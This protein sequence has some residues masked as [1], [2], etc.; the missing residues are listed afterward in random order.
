MT[1]YCAN[2]KS[3]PERLAAI[4]GLSAYEIKRA[5][6]W[7][8]FGKERQ[9]EGKLNRVE[10]LVFLLNALKSP[11]IDYLTASSADNLC[12]RKLGQNS[13]YPFSFYRYFDFLVE[14]M[15]DEIMVDKISRPRKYCTSEKMPKIEAER[16][17]RRREAARERAR[18]SATYIPSSLKNLDREKLR[19]LI[20][21]KEGHLYKMV[22]LLRGQNIRTN[23]AMLS[24]LIIQDK[25]LN[26]LAK[27]VRLIRKIRKAKEKPVSQIEKPTVKK[28]VKPLPPATTKE[29][30]WP[31]SKEEKEVLSVYQDGD[32]PQVLAD[33]TK[34]PG[35]R[36]GIIIT[37][38]LTRKHVATLG[39]AKEKSKE[40]LVTV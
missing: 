12:Y 14:K 32:S 5:W 2:K 6:D 29:E 7:L 35:G 20:E 40:E 17:Q 19:Q 18:Y 1:D 31:L 11:E 13:P 15:P 16:E 34:K 26:E 33:K 22:K 38:I 9:R 25:D 28:E 10:M 23:T 24:R 37:S 3:E 21:E 39:E 27:K 30:D 36:V 8:V 4:W